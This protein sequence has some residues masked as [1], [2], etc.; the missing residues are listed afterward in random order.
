MTPDQFGWIGQQW[1][2]RKKE[3]DEVRNQSVET[4]KEGGVWGRNSCKEEITNIKCVCVLGGENQ[5]GSVSGEGGE[6]RREG[7]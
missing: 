5:S 6:G 3:G 1:R 2:W 7:V 4:K